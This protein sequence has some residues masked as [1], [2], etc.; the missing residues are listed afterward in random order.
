ME[1]TNN[2]QFADIY[3]IGKCLFSFINDEV[4]QWKLEWSISV[5]SKK[6]SVWVQ[7]YVRACAYMRMEYMFSSFGISLHPVNQQ[8]LCKQTHSIIPCQHEHPIWLDPDNNHIQTVFTCRRPSCPDSW[9]QKNQRHVQYIE[10]LALYIS[11]SVCPEV[12]YCR[13]LPDNATYV[14]T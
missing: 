1:A 4:T 12:S 13:I 3:K 11:T 2:K 6:T 8:R 9:G 5:C 10:M 14:W 7:A